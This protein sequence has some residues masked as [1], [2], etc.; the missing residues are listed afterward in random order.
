VHVERVRRWRQ[1]HPG[2][3]RKPSLSQNALQ[4]TLSVETVDN[5]AVTEHLAQDALQDV[6]SAQMPVMLGLIAQLTG[7]ALQ[8]DI[9][10]SARRL[11]QLGDDILNPQFPQK[12]GSHDLKTHPMSG[13][14]QKTPGGLQLAGSS[15]GP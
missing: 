8:D 12:G 9:A 6:L 7:S 5:S 15:A 4:D 13:A 2:Y 10:A 11:R 14:G 1:S 3:W